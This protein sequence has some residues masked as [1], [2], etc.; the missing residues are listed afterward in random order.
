M[1]TQ[2][3]FQADVYQEIYIEK[4]DAK[5]FIPI[6]H[7]SVYLLDAEEPVF[8]KEEPLSDVLDRFIDFSSIPGGTV[9]EEQ[10]TEMIEQLEALKAVV[11]AKI[12]KAKTL[13]QWSSKSD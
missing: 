1:K 8:C 6:V 9:T 4:D 2:L 13:P 7:Q 5:Q 3:N 10:R 12:E 11:E